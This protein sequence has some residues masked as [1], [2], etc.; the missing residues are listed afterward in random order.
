MGSYLWVFAAD[1]FDS[2]DLDSSVLSSQHPQNGASIDDGTGS[3]IRQLNSVF[4][5]SLRY[6]TLGRILSSNATVIVYGVN[7]C[8]H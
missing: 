8:F 6:L 4:H 1:Y 3:P 2:G 5:L 7:Y